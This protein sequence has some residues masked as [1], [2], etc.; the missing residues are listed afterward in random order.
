VDSLSES[1]IGGSIYYHCSAADP[2]CDLQ[3]T[4]TTAFEFNYASRKGGA[5]H[6]TYYEPKIGPNVSFIG[7]KA[8]W[9]GDSISSYAT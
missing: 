5:I 1:G 9:Y 8:G 4:G 2:K 6:Y 3:I 7:N